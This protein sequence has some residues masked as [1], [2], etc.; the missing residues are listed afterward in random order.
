M[1]QRGIRDEWATE[2]PYF[3]ALHMGYAA[4]HT[5]AM[6]LAK[7]QAHGLSSHAKEIWYL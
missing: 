4:L 6:L 3:A 7:D 2:A 1:P 5:K